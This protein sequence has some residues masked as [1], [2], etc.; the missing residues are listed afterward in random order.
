LKASTDQS[1]LLIWLNKD[2]TTG[3]IPKDVK[4][5]RSNNLKRSSPFQITKM[6]SANIAQGS[7]YPAIKCPRWENVENI[8]PALKQQ[9]GLKDK[10]EEGRAKTEGAKKP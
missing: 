4:T 3:F 5:T 8:P 10:Q 6:F 1:L 7:S 9:L 2:F